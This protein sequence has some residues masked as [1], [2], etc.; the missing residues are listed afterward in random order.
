MHAALS[1]IYPYIIIRYSFIG[2][3]GYD[4]DGRTTHDLIIVKPFTSS[5]A[6]FQ[7]TIEE[8][9]FF[10]SSDIADDV[11]GGLEQVPKLSWENSSRILFHIANA[12]W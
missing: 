10:G 8:V 7:K 3:R 6:E 11:F 5:V 12:P 1:P 9:N 2:Y 4:K